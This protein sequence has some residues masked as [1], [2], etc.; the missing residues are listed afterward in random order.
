MA[1]ERLGNDLSNPEARVTIPPFASELPP[2]GAPDVSY[3]GVTFGSDVIS[4]ASGDGLPAA[5]V[6]SDMTGLAMHAVVSRGRAITQSFGSIVLFGIAGAVGLS[7]IGA[8]HLLGS[9]F[10]GSRGIHVAIIIALLGTA[11]RL[12]S[13]AWD[14]RHLLVVTT[15]GKPVSFLLKP[16][17]EPFQLIKTL[18]EVQ[19]KLGYVVD[20]YPE[21]SSADVQSTSV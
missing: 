10:L 19:Q 7:A 9:S 17:P 13:T 2:S 21:Q 4:G 6:R 16:T 8:I 11:W 12:F 20:L 3:C 5:V 18:E 1:N 14:P 15:T